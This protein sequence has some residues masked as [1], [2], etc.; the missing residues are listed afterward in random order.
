MNSCVYEWTFENIKNNQQKFINFLDSELNLNKHF[1]IIN[2]QL[3]PENINS[4]TKKIINEVRTA[5]GEF[6]NDSETIDYFQQW[7]YNFIEDYVNDLL[8]DFETYN[9][10]ESIL[11]ENKKKYK[12]IINKIMKATYEK[13]KTS[14]YEK[15]MCLE[16]IL[17]KHQKHFKGF[18]KIK[19]I[20]KH[21]EQWNSAWLLYLSCNCIFEANEIKLSKRYVADS[22]GEYLQLKNNFL[23]QMDLLIIEPSEVVWKEVY[24]CLSEFIIVINHIKSIEEHKKGGE[25]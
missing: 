8:I 19:D 3:Y 1:N 25:N 24:K 2:N 11:L 12:N 9:K 7:K 6:Y 16:S 17:K 15:F 14:R 20:E 22:G 18:V 13:T 10:I 21:F 23:N 5:I 4:D